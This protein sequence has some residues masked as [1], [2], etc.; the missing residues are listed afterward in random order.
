[1]IKGN[2]QYNENVCVFVPHDI[3]TL[4]S[5][6]SHSREEL[7]IGVSRSYTKGSYVA[8]LNR[9]GNTVHLGTFNTVEEAFYAYKTAKEDYIKEV[10][11]KWKD[12]VDI[13]VY[14]TLMDWSISIND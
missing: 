9:Y 6:S 1:M 4:L 3:N 7:P 13:R 8:C 11:N 14:K 5:Q 10:A 2:R 12:M